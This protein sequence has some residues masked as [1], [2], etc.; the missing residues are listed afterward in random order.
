MIQVLAIAGGGAIGALLRFWVSGWVY[1]VAG[2]AFPYGT[3]AVNVLG[4]LA[5]GFL[6]VWLLERVA[7]G[8]A[9][10]AF[11]L[12]GLL[13]AFTTFSTFSL[14]TL[15]LIEAGQL[16]RAVANMLL[17]VVLCVAAASIGVLIARQL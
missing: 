13:G 7:G 9:W 10:R 16:G 15:N 17:S 1:A 11:L 3:L 5:I 12:I 4:S 2:R 8:V 6:Y 14:E